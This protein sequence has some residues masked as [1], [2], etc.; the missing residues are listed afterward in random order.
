MHCV[1]LLYTICLMN[2]MLH[3]FPED[4]LNLAQLVEIVVNS[5]VYVKTD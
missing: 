3:C 4:V 1:A 2:K 5:S